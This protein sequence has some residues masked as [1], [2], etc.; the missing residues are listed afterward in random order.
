MY[1]FKTIS[2][3]IIGAQLTLSSEPN[4]IDVFVPNDCLK[5][6]KPSDHL[7]IEFKVIQNETV[8]GAAHEAPGQLFHILLDQSDHLPIH[9]GLKGMCENATRTLQW[10]SALKLDLSPLISTEVFEDVNE[11][12]HVTLRIVHITESSE[13]EIFDA[14]KQ[15]NISRVLDIIDE[16]RGVNAMD[17]W[18]QT[19]L[20][21]AVQNDDLTVVSAL[22]NARKPKVEVNLAK[23][24]GYSALHYAV[25]RKTPVIM[26]ALLKRGANPNASLLQKGAYGNTPLHFACMLEKVSHAE[27]LLEYGANISAV[28]EFGKKPLDLVPKDAVPSVRM[29]FKRMFTESPVYTARGE[30]RRRDL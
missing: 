30:A 13:Y 18:N 9:N 17:E 12:V 7:L 22:L 26:K 24:S 16:S 10:D 19:P 29:A 25:V 23:A 11:I 21:I 1:L 14:Y 15:G 5:H 2:I 27:L 28:N 8:I 20:I 3:L 6:A 4:I